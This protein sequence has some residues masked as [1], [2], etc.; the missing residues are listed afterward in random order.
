[1]HSLK[2]IFKNTKFNKCLN[3]TSADFLDQDRPLPCR[4][5][6]SLRLPHSCTSDTR[7]LL[8]WGLSMRAVL[9]GHLASVPCRTLSATQ[10]FKVKT[11]CTPNSQNVRYE[12]SALCRAAPQQFYFNYIPIFQSNCKNF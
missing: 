3:N 1:M 4:G 10:A 8:R 5:V 9:R 11:D 6:P 7:K 2:L 12:F